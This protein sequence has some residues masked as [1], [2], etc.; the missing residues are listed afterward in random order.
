VIAE[1]LK[2][3]YDAGSLP[4]R[5]AVLAAKFPLYPGLG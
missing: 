5:V 3:S 4:A 1:A 2:P